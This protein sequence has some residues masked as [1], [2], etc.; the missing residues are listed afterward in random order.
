M[1]Y[2]DQDFNF[3]YFVIIKIVSTQDSANALSFLIENDVYSILVES[4]DLKNRIFED[5]FYFKIQI[6]GNM[7]SGQDIQTLVFT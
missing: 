2:Q 5:N 4:L 1:L 7:L 3:R 6:I